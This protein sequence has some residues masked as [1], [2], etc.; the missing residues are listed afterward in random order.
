VPEEAFA[1]NPL[2]N[3]FVEGIPKVKGVR[4]SDRA[5]QK[6]EWHDVKRVK[7]W[8]DGWYIGYV[9]N[10]E[11]TAT[12]GSLMGHCAG[13]HYV[14]THEE[15]IWYFFALFD[16]SGVPHSTLHAKQA[17]WMNKEHP[18]DNGEEIPLAAQTWNVTYPTLTVVMECFKK[19]GLE[20]KTGKYKPARYTS[21]T[22][23]FLLQD[24]DYHDADTFAY[25][26]GQAQCVNT[27]P[28]DVDENVWAAYVK[29]AK[30]VEDN[31]AK[32]RGAIRVVGRRFKFDGKWLILLSASNKSQLG[33][34]GS[35][36]KRIAE[37]LNGIGK[38]K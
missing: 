35:H 17:S 31:F 2:E 21:C 10:P 27:R 20:Y 38:G 6:Y 33:A 22:Y 23:D 11:D 32:N 4:G 14:W 1:F 15:R 13:A 16:P 3:Q 28:K 29:A 19:A 34:D 9:D 24:R 36:G 7:E 5:K 30:A 12:L 37:W 18:R 26:I 25:Q 8:D